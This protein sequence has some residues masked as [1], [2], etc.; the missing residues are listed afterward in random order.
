MGARHAGRR[1]RLAERLRHRHRSRRHAIA[2]RAGR[3]RR[4]GRSAAKP[5]RPMSPADRGRRRADQAADAPEICS[6]GDRPHIA[7]VG[8]SA[9]GPLDSET[10]TVIAIPTLPGW[11]DLPLGAILP[12]NSALPVVVENDGIAAANG[13]WR[14]GS[15]RGSAALRLCDRQHRHRRRRRGRRPSAARPPRP[16]RPCRPH[17]HRAG[18]AASAPAV[19]TAASRRSPPAAR[20]P[21]PAARR[22]RPTRR[23]CSPRT[24]RARSPRA[25]SSRRRAPGDR[26]ALDAARSRGGLARHRL[27]QSRAPLQPAGGRSWAAAS[28]RRSISCIPMIAAAFRSSAMPPFRDVEIVAAMLGDN[29]GLAGAAALVWERQGQSG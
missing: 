7:G 14:F 8:V 27:L 13:E 6:A 2:R 11:E 12:R 24:R 23:A 29:A 10:G 21:A 3:S 26:L 19:R 18:R 4:R 1:L 20:W 5:S 15:A 17:D 22:W 9:P 16:G 28:R 25:T